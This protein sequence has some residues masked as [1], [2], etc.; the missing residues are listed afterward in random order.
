[1]LVEVVEVE[2]D[3]NNITIIN[4]SLQKNSNNNSL[5]K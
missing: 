5:I 2:K 3:M 1:M 4:N